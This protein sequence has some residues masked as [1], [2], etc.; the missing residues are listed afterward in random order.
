MKKRLRLMVLLLFVLNLVGLIWL[1]LLPKDDS[2]LKILS[3]TESFLE[4]RSDDSKL[5]HFS[6]EFPAKNQPTKGNAWQ[7]ESKKLKTTFETTRRKI[8]MSQLISKYEAVVKIQSMVTKSY[9]HRYDQYRTASYFAMAVLFLNAG[10]LLFLAVV[11]ESLAENVPCDE[12]PV[13][14][15]PESS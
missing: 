1:S 12:R 11:I 4:N 9:A 6:S 3:N 2:F 15:M 13:N 7:N 5:D 10:F 8:E 14:D